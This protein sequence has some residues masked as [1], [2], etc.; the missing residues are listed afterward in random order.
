MKSVLCRLVLGDLALLCM[1][2]VSYCGPRLVRRQNSF[3]LSGIGLTMKEKLSHKPWK[4]RIW[5]AIVLLSSLRIGR[6]AV[7]EV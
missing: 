6:L 3:S 4:S 2:K 1:V 5:S 7:V